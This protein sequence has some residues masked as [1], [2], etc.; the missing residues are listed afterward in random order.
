[1]ED[2]GCTCLRSVTNGGLWKEN[3]EGSDQ[4]RVVG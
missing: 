4:C 3:S 2:F 1:M